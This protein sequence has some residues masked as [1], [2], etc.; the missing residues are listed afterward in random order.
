MM[1][2]AFLV[3]E[4][5]EEA[6]EDESNMPSA[7]IEAERK[8]ILRKAHSALVLSLADKVLREVTKEKTAK[9]I[10]EMLEARYIEKSLANRFYLKKKLYAFHLNEGIKIEDED[11]ALIVLTSLPPSYEHFVDTLLYGRTSVSLDHV[12]STLTSKELN[13]KAEANFDLADALVARGRSNRRDYKGKKDSRSR[14]KGKKLKCFH[15]HKEGHFRRDCPDWKLQNRNRSTPKSA[16]VAVVTEKDFQEGFLL[17]A[18][19]NSPDVEWITNSG[20]TFHMSLHES[21]FSSL[22]STNGG[23]VLMGNNVACVACEVG[24]GSIRIKMYDGVCRELQNVR[25]VP[26]LKR[27]LISLG[28][29]D[30]LGCSYKAENG[31]LKVVKGSLVIIKGIRKN[32]LYI[33]QGNTV[34]GEAAISGEERKDKTLIWHLRLGHIGEKGLR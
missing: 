28:M 4:G 3:Y 1:T 25:Y 8:E 30:R 34:C 10:W 16:D 21:S 6:L 7:S 32:G 23:K 2:R 29:V 11:Q 13:K 22:A 14:F 19:D 5:L 9:G 20:C 15:C 17:I 33:L 24:I 27:N 31:V 26:E 18:S 12:K